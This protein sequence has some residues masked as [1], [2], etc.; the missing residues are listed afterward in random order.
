MFS[1]FQSSMGTLWCSLAH[2]SVMWPLHG[3]YEC[4]TCGRRYAAF[5]EALVA[6]RAGESTGAVQLPVGRQAANHA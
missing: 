3:H 1:R 6:S 5:E 2:E 4:R